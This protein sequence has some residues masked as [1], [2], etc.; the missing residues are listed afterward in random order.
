MILA[1][2]NLGSIEGCTVILEAVQ[3][4]L[5]HVLEYSDS[6][7]H[8]QVVGQERSSPPFPC[9]QMQLHV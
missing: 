3:P 4:H 2:I 7:G 6:S 8:G 1:L 9:L 5:Q